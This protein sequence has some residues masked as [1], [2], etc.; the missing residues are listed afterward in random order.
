[1]LS[2]L[3]PGYER[4]VFLEGGIDGSRDITEGEVRTAITRLKNNK[5]LGDTWMSAELLK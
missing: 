3:P 5:A 4:E 2:C 1:M